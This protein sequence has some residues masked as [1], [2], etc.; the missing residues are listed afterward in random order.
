[1]TVVY[2]RWKFISV[3]CPSPELCGPGHDVVILL[4]IPGVWF[5]VLTAQDGCKMSAIMPVFQAAGWRKGV[6]G[7]HREGSGICQGHC[8]SCFIS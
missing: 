8:P 1:M 7:A 6:K 4:Q 5:H 3:S 2:R